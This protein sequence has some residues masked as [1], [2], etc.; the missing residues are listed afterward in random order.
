M[1]FWK[2]KL[3]CIIWVVLI[4]TFYFVLGN[5]LL[6]FPGGSD[7]KE[8]TCNA[9][10]PGSIPGLG[11]C[12]GE[13]NDNPLQGC[14]AWRIPN[15]PPPSPQWLSS[16]EP[17]C[18]AGASGDMGSIHQSVRSLGGGHG[19]PLQCSC[20]ENPMDRRTWWATVHR[21]TKSWTW[22]RAGHDWATEHA[23]TLC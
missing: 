6:G 1:N 23:C 16:K 15:P 4:L 2:R 17:V 5:S 18:S 8:S 19:N 9:R 21:V 12:P 14:P 7:S 13:G 22:L 3:S 20:L 10:D 11:R